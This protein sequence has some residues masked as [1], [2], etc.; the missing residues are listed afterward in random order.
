MLNSAMDTN[1]P[2]ANENS[3]SHL[4]DMELLLKQTC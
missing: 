4:P 1:F 2:G 3:S